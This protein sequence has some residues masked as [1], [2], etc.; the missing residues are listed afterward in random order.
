MTLKIAE[1]LEQ[2]VRSDYVERNMNMQVAR[3]E[4]R[5]A[6]LIDAASTR[7][8]RPRFLD[9]PLIPSGV[10]TLIAGRAGVSKSTLS[11]NRA[12]L[13]TRGRLNGDYERHPV[14]VCFSGIEDSAS[15]QKARLI[16]ADANLTHVRFL[17]ITDTRNGTSVETGLSIPRDLP[18]IRDLL[19]DAGI[20]LWV[21]DPITSCIPGDTNKRDDVRAALD[22]L[23]A[24]AADLDIAIVGILHFNKGGG[25]ASDKVS[26]SHAFRD[27]VRSLILVSKDDETGDVV[28]T[29]DKSNYTTA[30]GTSFSYALSS[31]DVTDDDGQTMSV[32]VVTGLMPTERTVNEIINRNMTPAQDTPRTSA[33][34]IIDWLTEFLRDGSAA[35]N[36]IMRAATPEGYTR[37]QIRHAQ[38]TAADPWI[39]SE[40]DP[41]YQ[42]RGQRRLWRLSATRPTD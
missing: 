27:A 39:V 7:M 8:V 18:E 37:R 38:E 10:L 41:D 11:I 17:T 30:A 33:N 36:D 29:V 25:Y 28:M 14:N 22:P 2:R 6:Q 35:F 34:E 26:G 1:T 40:P 21:I 15:M 16:A 23:A 31:C 13:A 4:G 3:A 19:K 5:H 42:G 12:A 24:L 20:R 32:P 9:Y